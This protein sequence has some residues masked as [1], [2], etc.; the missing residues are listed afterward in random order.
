MDLL[1]TL[2]VDNYDSYT[3]NLLQL[4]DKEDIHKNVVVIRNDQFEW[5]YFVD[6]IC[7]HFDNIIISP[8]PGRPDNV[9]DFGICTR[10]L[11]LDDVPILGVC[12]GHQGIGSVFGAQIIRARNI[13]HGRL[14]PIYHNGAGLF[15][16]IPNPFSAVRYHSLVVSNEDLPKDL[17]VIATTLDNEELTVMALKHARKPIYGSHGTCSFS[18]IPSHI[19]SLSAFPAI[20]GIPPSLSHTTT[21]LQIVFNKLDDDCWRDPQLIF[22]QIVSLDQSTLGTWWLDSAREND[23]QCQY[24]YMGST[25]ASSSSFS[26]SYLTK[27]KQLQLACSNGRLM[28]K[29]LLGSTTFWDWMTD[30][31]NKLNSRIKSTVVMNNNQIICDTIP[32][33]FHLGM[34]GFFGYEMKIESLP[35]YVVPSKQQVS[36]HKPDAAFIFATQAVIFDHR[37]R[38]IW[39]GCLIRQ[40]VEEYILDDIEQE[41]GINIGISMEE[42][43]SWF[44]RMDTKI[45]GL[46]KNLETSEAIAKAEKEETE[47]ITPHLFPSFA[48]APSQTAFTPVLPSRTYIQQIKNA[49]SY[50]Q[51]GESYELCL[52]TQFRHTL[53]SRLPNLL[54]LYLY[55]RTH[56]PAP[57]SALL[58][59]TV[60]NLA[61][62]SS[63]P[64][65]FIEVNR[66]GEVEMKPIKGT[67]AVA[68]G[69]WCDDKEN[70]DGGIKCRKGAERENKK[71]VRELDSSVKERAENLMIVDL[72][73]NDLAQI[74]LPH[75]VKVP[76]LME[77]ESYE[78]VHQLVTTVCG[79]LR[80]EIDSVTAIKCCFPPGSMTGAPK[81]RS[82]QLLDKL[83]FYTPRGVYSGCLGYISL[84]YITR[85]NQYRQFTRGTAKFSVIIRTVVINSGTEVSV[86]AGGAILHLSDAK[87]EWDEVL[88]KSRAVIP[89]V[90]K[91]LN[92]R[93]FSQPQ[94][95]QQWSSG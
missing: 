42:C 72:I 13:M 62:L 67:M 21:P 65:K 41:V 56:N 15:N 60:D 52:T 19:L 40:N 9:S 10:I 81:L 8:G 82:V 35:G 31:T 83:E 64:E 23:T 79:Q 54:D 80:D 95:L 75:T 76:K 77:V 39:L 61:I 87:E 43:M 4:W 51:S 58:N 55:L 12:L 57:F 68:K 22:Q 89:S 63:S 30:I 7:P 1:R 93:V 66:L 53:T 92:D 71:R 28:S 29:P 16:R 3:F 91:Y 33:D 26:V 59:F 24:S 78:T 32:F 18:Q 2:I 11:Q 5:D 45:R 90:L 49:Q 34:V 69:C 20:A 74:C 84:P 38:N 6:N 17:M 46:K 36:N 73:R 86:G 47:P 44:R 85:S 70:C 25:P 14:S 27:T 88:V 94:L 50:I 48:A 37:E